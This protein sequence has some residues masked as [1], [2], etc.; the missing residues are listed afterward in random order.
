MILLTLLALA[1]AAPPAVQA[2]PSTF[3]PVI[4]S[5]ILC[6]SGLDNA[7]FHDYLVNAFGPS[8][9]HEG[10]AYWFKAEG[11]LW[12]APVT[13]IMISDDTSELVFV[14][15]VADT[16]P[17]KLEESIRNAVG[18]RHLSVDNS[19]YPVRASNPGS[20]IVYFKT[21]S[22][23]YCAKYKPLPVGR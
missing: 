11:T 5:A 16:T 1:A 19:R 12:G 9:K 13:D 23:I 20:K 10:G 2:A 22:K 6:R 7:Y 14:A 3:G 4:G 18:V 17:D 15:A 8:Y 21:K